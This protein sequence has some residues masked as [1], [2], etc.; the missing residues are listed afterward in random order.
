MKA[1]IWPARAALGPQMLAG[2]GRKAN[3][4]IPD[5]AI[6]SP[7]GDRQTLRFSL[8][9]ERGV[10]GRGRAA[11]TRMLAIWL[12]VEGDSFVL[13]I[14]RKKRDRRLNTSAS[15][16]SRR[17]LYVVWSSRTSFRRVTAGAKQMRAYSVA[18]QRETTTQHDI[19]HT[20]CMGSRTLFD[21]GLV[22]CIHI[23]RLDVLA[24][25]LLQGREAVANAAARHARGGET[26]TYQGHP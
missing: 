19:L 16:V 26:R 25:V 17:L 11:L 23:G 9:P 2:A 18:V 13:P 22:Q 15:V 20:Q 6:E 8:P 1:G 7:S 14:V 21:D 4:K 10:P 3:V 24:S 12:Y 5:A